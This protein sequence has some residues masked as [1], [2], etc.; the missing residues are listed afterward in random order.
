MEKSYRYNARKESGRSKDTQ[1]PNY[2]L[3]RIRL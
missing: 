2:C 3:V 1:T